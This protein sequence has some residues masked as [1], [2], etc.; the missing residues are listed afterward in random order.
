MYQI[1]KKDFQEIILFLAV[2]LK[3]LWNVLNKN[4]LVGF[5]PLSF[6]LVL[7]SGFLLYWFLSLYLGEPMPV[8]YQ[9]QGIEIYDFNY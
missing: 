1:M 7:L 9:P 6:L 8:V 3:T 2:C 4:L 5:L